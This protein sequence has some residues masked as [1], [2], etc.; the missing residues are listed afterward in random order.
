MRIFL[1][2]QSREIWKYIIN[3]PYIPTK[4]VDGIK[5]KKEEE[6]FDYEDNRLYTLNLTTMNLLYNAFN[7]NEF[8]RIMTCVTAKEIRD[9]L[10]VTYE[11]ISQL[12]A[13]SK[14]YS[15]VEIVRKILNSLPKRW[16]SKVI[17]IF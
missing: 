5:I 17:A 7:R 9:N 4:V 6:E 11:R 10:E 14:I 2:A 12:I 1:Q 8:N 15:K 13:F 3:G 16:E